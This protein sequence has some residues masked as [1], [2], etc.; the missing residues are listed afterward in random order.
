TATTFDSV[1]S[2]MKLSIRCRGG[3][4]ELS[5]AG[6][7]ISGRG[8]GYAVSSCTVRAISPPSME[9]RCPVAPVATVATVARAA[10]VR[11]RAI[12]PGASAPINSRRM[13]AAAMAAMV[14]VAA[15]AP[16]RLQ[17]EA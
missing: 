4:T 12:A 2:S 5:F 17:V 10:S 9:A 8:D 11:L 6:P 1:E 3:R 15:M 16:L 13:A 7:A 14:V